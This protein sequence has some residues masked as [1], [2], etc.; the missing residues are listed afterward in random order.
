MKPL[1]PVA[2]ACLIL[3]GCA[4]A[5]ADTPTPQASARPDLTPC[6]TSGGHDTH[7]ASETARYATPEAAA[8]AYNRWQAQFDVLVYVPR[9]GYTVVR[10]E[11]DDGAVLRRTEVELDATRDSGGWRISHVRACKQ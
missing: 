1:V 9:D 6:A 5:S 4:G 11:S 3:T 2:L 8:E 10:N 7:T